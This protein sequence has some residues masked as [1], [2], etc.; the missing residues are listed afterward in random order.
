MPRLFCDMDG[1]LADFDRGYAIV[2][3]REITPR[4]YHKDWSQDDWEALHK[5]APTFFRD[6]PLMPD[7][8]ELWTYIS[9]HSPTILTGV[10]KELNGTDVQKKAWSAA[11]F[12][13]TQPII[14]C[15]SKEKALHCR[16]GDIIIDDWGKYRHLWERA[17]GIWILHTSAKDS[18]EQ[19]KE[20]GL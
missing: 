10:P 8:S 12:G 14:C 15:R 1:V 18:I 2:M 9:P 20:L 17:G 16:P 7:A 5:A 3:G 4:D 19:L 13:P 6:L 11:H